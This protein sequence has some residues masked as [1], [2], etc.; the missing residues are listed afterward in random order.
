MRRAPPR[1]AAL[2]HQLTTPLSTRLLCCLVAVVAPSGLCLLTHTTSQHTTTTKRKQVEKQKAQLVRLAGAERLLEIR[3][4]SATGEVHAFELHDDWD[5]L[6]DKIGKVARDVCTERPAGESLAETL[7]NGAFEGE[8]I[9]LYCFEI[10]RKNHLLQ[11][12]FKP[13]TQVC[14]SFC[15]L[16]FCC[17]A[18]C[19][20][21]RVS[22]PSS[23]CTR[24]CVFTQTSIRRSRCRRTR[25]T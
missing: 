3:L 15:S 24:P 7:A 1:A 14:F 12:I 11:R 8:D 22:A 10:K 5:L 20:F 18:G 9:P 13:N 4:T 6:P 21:A 2:A 19:L 23:F 16:C 17:A 25:R